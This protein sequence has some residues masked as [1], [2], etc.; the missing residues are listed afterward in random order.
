M[1]MLA[2]VFQALAE[3]GAPCLHFK[4]KCQI[5]EKRRKQ[6]IAPDRWNAMPL[7]K[8]ATTAS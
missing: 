2:R 3:K 6:S 5:Q 4:R 8:E 1:Y 7:H